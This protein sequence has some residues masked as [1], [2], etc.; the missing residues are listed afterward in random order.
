MTNLYH[1]TSYTVFQSVLENNS[2]RLSEHNFLNDNG[3]INSFFS[4]INRV[5]DQNKG[6]CCSDDCCDVLFCNAKH[7][8]TKEEAKIAVQLFEQ[9][10]MENDIFN[11]YI[12]SMSEEKDKNVLWSN[13]VGND[14]LSFSLNSEK[15][16]E[17]VQKMNSSRSKW[18]LPYYNLH[19][20]NYINFND[21]EQIDDFL[22]GEVIVK[23]Y[24]TASDTQLKV[25]CF[26]KN[27]N[28]N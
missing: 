20:V 14:G 6:C 17:Y 25:H 8:I 5:I 4:L 1:Y 13:F 12:F 10:I 24:Y 18:D 22:S 3:E 27:K 19:R 2:L 21:N 15:I 26:Q 7:S 9:M 23:D 28:T 16:R 11:Y